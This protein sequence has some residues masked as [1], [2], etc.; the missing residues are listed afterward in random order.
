[1]TGCGVTVAHRAKREPAWAG[2][3]SAR[4]A[5][6]SGTSEALAD[7]HPLG[8][9]L[10]LCSHVPHFNRKKTMSN[11]RLVTSAVTFS[12]MLSSLST[13]MAEEGS[14]LEQEATAVRAEPKHAVNL[15]VGALWAAPRVA[16]EYLWNG[17]HGFVLEAGGFYWPFLDMKGGGAAVGYRWHWRG[18]QESGFLGLLAGYDVNQGTATVTIDGMEESTH[19]NYETLYVVGNIGKRWMLPSNLNV[20]ARLG[21]GY[22]RRRADVRDDSL[23]DEVVL[24]EIFGLVPWTLDAELSLGYTF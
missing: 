20:T 5:Y 2:R 21:A 22:A 17:S 8:L 19:V 10:A 24:D 4:G 13:A 9:P 15:S 12:L 3:A 7:A 6:I 1:M 16:Y 14:V 18:Q 11:I 23:A